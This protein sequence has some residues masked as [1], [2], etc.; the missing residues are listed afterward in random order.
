MKDCE[1]KRQAMVLE[2]ELIEALQKSD[3]S[4][5]TGI[6]R[7]TVVKLFANQGWEMPEGLQPAR[8][9]EPLHVFT[10]WDAVKL[11]TS[12]PSYKNLSRPEDYATKLAHL[13]GF[14]QKGQACEGCLDI[15]FEVV[16]YYIGQTKGCPTRQ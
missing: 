16:S 14:F 5:L 11:Y 2:A 1:S 15:G 7:Q 13:V 10:L 4:N 6:A 3:Y 12:D 9:K 8:A